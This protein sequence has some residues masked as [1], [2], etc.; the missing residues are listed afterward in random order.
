MKEAGGIGEI[1]EQC[2]ADTVRIFDTIEAFVMEMHRLCEHGIDK[3]IDT[4]LPEVFSLNY[5]VHSLESL[6][7]D[8][9]V[10]AGLAKKKIKGKNKA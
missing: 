4:S 6:F 5:A 3:D 2:Q 10:N 9:L 8:K 7:T 1:A